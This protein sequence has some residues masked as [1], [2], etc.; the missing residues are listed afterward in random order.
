MNKQRS[1]ERENSAAKAR[2]Y[3]IEQGRLMAI[4]KL[5]REKRLK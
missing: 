2:D 5:E 1:N 3:E 4:K